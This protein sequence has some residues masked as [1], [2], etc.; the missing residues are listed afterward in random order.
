MTRQQALDSILSESVL[1]SISSSR[2]LVVG[3]GGI[4]CELMKNLALSGFADI[5]LVGHLF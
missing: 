5:T 2:I 3:A 1:S 4:G